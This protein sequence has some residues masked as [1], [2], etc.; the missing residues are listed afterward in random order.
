MTPK[1]LKLKFMT[2]VSLMREYTHGI[3]DSKKAYRMN[4][5]NHNSNLA[6]NVA[7][8]TIN[9]KIQKSPLRKNAVQYRD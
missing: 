5:L 4:Q 3:Q 2:N 6:K 8:K 9:Y 7:L 1:E